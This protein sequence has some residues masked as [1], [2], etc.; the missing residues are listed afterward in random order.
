MLI[1][2]SKFWTR[3]LAAALIAGTGV[4][5]TSCSDDYI[6]DDHEPDNLGQSIYQYLQSQGNFT[7]MLRLIDDLGYKEMLVKTGSKT[8]FPAD[9]EAFERFFKSNPY[10]ATCYEDL[11]VSQRRMIM[12][13]AMVDMAYL[14]D[15]LPNLSNND[16]SD[17]GGKSSAL[18]RATSASNMDSVQNV[19]GSILPKTKYWERFAD[20]KV[21]LT[22]QSPMMVHFTPQW[23]KAQGVT[24]N[25]FQTIFGEPYNGSDI[26]INGV[27]VKQPD[28]ICKNGYIHV[29]EEVALPSI[30]MAEAIELEDDITIFRGLLDKFCAPYYDGNIDAQV[31][32]YYN[33]STALRPL[34]PGMS[35]T[36]SV[37]VK[38][39]FNE[40]TASSGPKGENLSNYGMLYYDPNNTV[41]GGNGDMGVMFVPTDEAMMEYFS[42]SEG[43]YLRDSYDSWDD[44]PTELVASFLKNHQKRSFMSSL[45]HLWPTLTDETSYAI[46]ITPDNVVK[47]VL[48]SNGV[49]YIINK[50][51]P[52]IDY[53]GT[54]A[55]V[56]TAP[57]TKVMK[58]ALTDNWN[59]LGDQGAMCF[60]MYLRSM[61]NMY[62][63]IV[64]TDEAL[65]NYREPISWALGGSNRRIWEFEYEED[66]DRVVA[67]IYSVNGAMEKGELL[68]E[69][70]DKSV[71]RN[72]LTDIIDMCIVVGNNDNDVLSGYL[73]DSK[74]NYFL[75][76]GGAT[77]YATGKGK[78]VSFNGGGDIELGIPP[79]KVALTDAGRDCIY[80]S[81]NGRTFFIDRII[82]DPNQ[83]VYDVLNSRRGYSKFLELC[84]GD[85]SV[86]VH[87]ADDPEFVD[88]FSSRVSNVTNTSGIGQCVS[89][90]NNYRYT[91]FVPTNDA[92]DAAFAADPD[93]WTWTEIAA[94]EDIDIK[95][96]RALYL[97]RF[98]RYH[99]VDNSAYISGDSYGPLRYET[100][101]RDEYNRFRR[102]M[103]SSNGRNMTITDE[104]GN[105]A[106]VVT[107]P[108][109]YNLMARDIIVN[110]HDP[111]AAN[112]IF[113]SS[114]AVI[115]QIDRALTLKK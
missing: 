92:I 49:V 20:S 102:I 99:F 30:T 4:P 2:V 17:N 28:V 18:R 115:H 47:S 84:N 10:G 29:M 87:F 97:L 16:N 59:D 6:Y 33:G 81:Q 64:P 69:E 60:F 58:W 37:F 22:A 23:M 107:T 91:V 82:H 98:L 83:T 45:P 90:F 70:T 79:T 42:G 106:N 50:V 24:N 46:K 11:T 40:Q 27:R 104:C 41:F 86:S 15:M 43:G 25:D 21:F 62:N 94:E 74:S 89:S 36:D 85:E 113:A 114:R 55:S 35:S 57:N 56:L 7:Y 95:R 75:T 76:K 78:N 12:N 63:L 14:S 52:P 19:P 32:E 112:Q 39:Y 111:R 48:T 93:L 68:R 34:I 53:K 9:D 5:F 66:R 80:D 110:N 100:A 88:I 108:G 65:L 105:N 109:M 38:R 8:L 54:Y 51:I 71:I 103:V 1:K 96:E 61:E 77:I 44:V 26:F 72:R 3:L 31:K 73:N 101:A 67:H 13:A